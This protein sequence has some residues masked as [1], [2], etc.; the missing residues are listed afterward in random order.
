MI[1]AILIVLCVVAIC[2]YAIYRADRRL[3][4]VLTRYEPM[5][6]DELLDELQRPVGP[7]NRFGGNADQVKARFES[8]CG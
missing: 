8:E 3:R 2:V 7:R 1:Y 5:T 4:E 6:D